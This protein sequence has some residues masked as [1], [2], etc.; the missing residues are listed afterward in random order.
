MANRTLARYV[1]ASHAAITGSG[2]RM[3][4]PH[5]Q[6]SVPNARHPK[7]DVSTLAKGA[8][9]AAVLSAMIAIAP[10][11]T[12]RDYPPKQIGAWT[13]AASED[14]QGCFLTRQ[15]DDVGD[16]T[17][18]LGL[19]VD[20]TN[21]LSVLNDNWS[22]KPKQRL[23]LSF[24]LSKG[25]YKDQFSIGLASNGKQGFVTTFEVRFV[26]Y[27]AT[28]EALQI[29]RGTIPVAQLDLA[30]SG[31]A[32]A[33]LRRCVEAHRVAAAAK[34]AKKPRPNAIPRDP[35]AP[36]PKARDRR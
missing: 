1:R 9:L 17:L 4:L 23:K 18:L 29:T 36:N 15:Y 14:G 8:T 28:S 26:T 13:L 12:A 2:T 24:R 3:H 32:V 20:G 31:A 27:F 30:G 33:E 11:A 10:P 35:F 7:R 22:I 19:D 5:D 16:T 21:H 34:P 25:G 6:I